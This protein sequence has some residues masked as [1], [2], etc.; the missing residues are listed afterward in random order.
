MTPSDVTALSSPYIFESSRK[1]TEVGR[2]SKGLLMHP[3]GTIFMTSRATIGEF[4]LSLRG[5][6]TTNQGFIVVKPTEDYHRWF[7]FEEMRS[8]VDE[9]HQFANGSTFLELSRGKFKQLPVGVY[10]DDELQSLD[11]ILM[12]LQ[13]RSEQLAFE[14][15]KLKLLRDSLLPELLS[16]RITPEQL[17]A[18]L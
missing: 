10:D 4:A 3:A 6:M 15:R 13:L 5:P 8:R 1:I 12:P 2:E 11:R 14:N 17:E 7:L 9:F 16:G 18:G